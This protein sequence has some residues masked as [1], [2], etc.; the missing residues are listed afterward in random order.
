MNGTS[1]TRSPFDSVLCLGFGNRLPL[2]VRRIVRPTAGERDDVIDH[3]SRSA[4]WVPGLSHEPT[5][6][7]FASR[8]PSFC[9]ARAGGAERAR[10]MAGGDTR[11]WPISALVA[12]MRG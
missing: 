10:V 1:A 6:C 12:S 5:L 9:G 8:D 3:V 11:W 7:V 2:H 4:V